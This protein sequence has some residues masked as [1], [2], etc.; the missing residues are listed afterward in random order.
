MESN[1]LSQKSEPA[2]IERL[3]YTTK[4]TCTALGVSSTTLWRIQARGLLHPIPGMRNKL[5]SVAAIHR[6]VNQSK[7]GAA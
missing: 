4:E 1:T 7:A 5:F 3:T 6:F 2:I